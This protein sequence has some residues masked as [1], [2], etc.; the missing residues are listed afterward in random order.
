VLA[1]GRPEVVRYDGVDD[2]DAFGVGLACGGSIDVLIEPHRDDDV[3]RALRGDLG[4]GRA[5]VLCVAVDPDRLRG[6]RV[7]LRDDGSHCGGIDPVV[8]EVALA[9][10]REML[11]KGGTR[12]LSLSGGGSVFVEAFRPPLRLYLVGATHTA[13][14][15]CAMATE[16]GY[17]VTVIDA[18]SAFATEERFP[19]AHALV[20][21]PPVEAFEAIALDADAHVVTLTHD[22]K[23][24]LPALAVALESETGYIGALGSRATHA[25]RLLQLREQ[26]FGEADLARIHAP[27]GL[28]IGGRTP[29]EVALSILSELVADRQGRDGRPLAQRAAPI[30]DER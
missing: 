18:R 19:E 1:S 20:G 13:I 9:A 3:W 23:F 12:T 7:A 11:R 28:D 15:L 27:V 25:R 14:P 26:G 30:H 10:A 29:E 24:D 22:P 8:D 2:G 4:D 6:R 5:A 21:K 17:Q 16:L